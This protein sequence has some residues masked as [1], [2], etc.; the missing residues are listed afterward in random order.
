LFSAVVTVKSILSVCPVGVSIDEPSG[1]GVVV[2]VRQ[3]KQRGTY[4]RRRVG[5]GLPLR[6]VTPLAPEADGVASYRKSA[7]VVSTF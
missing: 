3:Q 5:L 6:E 7:P 1:G 4:I 2:A